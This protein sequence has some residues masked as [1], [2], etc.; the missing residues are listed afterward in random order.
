MKEVLINKELEK[1][2]ENVFGKMD[3]IMKVSGKMEK[4]MGLVFI[5]KKKVL[6][7]KVNG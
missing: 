4:G 5:H 2:K 3:L 7:T 1:D 6:Y